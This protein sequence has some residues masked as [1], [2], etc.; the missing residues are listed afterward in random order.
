M[1]PRTAVI[2]AC[3]LLGA[4]LPVSLVVGGRG[5]RTEGTLSL[6]REL[7]VAIPERLAG[8]TGV[9][10]PLSDA[11]L[12]IIKVDDHVK[13]QYAGPDGERV[14]LY[15]TFHGNKERGLQTYYH[16]ASVCYP[17]AGYEHVSTS[18]RNLVL[19]E[20][21]KE[22]P[23]CRY[24]FQKGTTRLSVLTFF[25]VDDELLDQSPRNKPFWSALDRLTPEFDDSPG[26]FVQV[27][28]I[29]PV[30]DGGDHAAERTQVRFLE[31]FGRTIFDAVEVAGAAR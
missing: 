11:E 4:A 25:K 19:T 27:Q 29:V 13:R 15:V 21:A 30:T 14:V 20:I 31:A 18:L 7:R 1:T 9:E 16:N 23:V 10:E 28:V 12:A 24:V 8:W 22:V 2:V 3:V 5:P 17:Q 6:A 26:T